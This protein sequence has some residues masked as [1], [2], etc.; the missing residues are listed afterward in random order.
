MPTNR[1]VAELFHEVAD[2]LDVLGERFKPE[3]YRRAARSIESLTEDLAQV[4]ARN[5]LRTIPGVGDAIEEKIGEFLKTGHIRYYDQLQKQVP[6]GILDLLRLPGLGPKTARRFWLELGVEGPAELADAISKGRLDGVKGFGPKKIE[7]IR[8]A[9]AAAKGGPASARLPIEV[10]YPIAQRL[11]TELRAAPGTVKAELA[12]SF[13]RSRETV[14]DLDVLV[15]SED[16]EK[17]FDAFS[18]FPEVKEVMLRGGTKESVV[19]TQGIQVDL[20]VVEPEEFGAA[21]VYF[22]GSKDHNVRLRTMAQERGLKINEYGVLRGEERVG[23]RTEADVYATLDLA[24]IPPELR[25]DR[26]EI[27]AAAKGPLPTLVESADLV[28]ELHVH[29]PADAGAGEVDRWVAAARARKLTYLGLVVASVG[30]DEAGPPSPRWRWTDWTR[31]VLPGSPSVGP[32]RS[33]PRASR[34]TG[35]GSNPIT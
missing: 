9:L 27:D 8:L 34:R 26:G 23:G 35:R 28:G 2:I 24:W 6:P 22:T 29:L 31:Y 32:S 16:P 3:A 12:G 17:V 5:E 4:A 7:Q 20:R 25:E 1:E 21:W 10:A 14:G 18:R 30:A 13:R 33:A 15:T 11:L 19:L